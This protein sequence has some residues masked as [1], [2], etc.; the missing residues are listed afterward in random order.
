LFVFVSDIGNLIMER[1]FAVPDLQPGTVFLPTY[2][3]LVHSSAISNL[4]YLRKFL[5]LHHRHYWLRFFIN[6]FVDMLL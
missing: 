6:G 2:M 1:D 4:N 5:L 3:Y